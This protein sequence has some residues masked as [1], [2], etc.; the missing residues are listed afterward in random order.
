[1]R[2]EI[3]ARQRE[4]NL[5]GSANTSAI[6]SDPIHFLPTKVKPLYVD[7]NPQSEDVAALKAKLTEGL[8]QYRQDY[9]AYYE[10]CKRP[11]SPAMR[12]PNPTG[13][14]DQ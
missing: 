13:S 10:R 1:M 7:W 14:R 2:I 4:L 6:A 8:E 9:A 11:N 3:S 12:D 5:T